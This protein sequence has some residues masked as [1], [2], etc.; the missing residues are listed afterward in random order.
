LGTG[1]FYLLFF[2]K[3]TRWA[4]G[5]CLL[6]IA[7]PLT[8]WFLFPTFQNRIKYVLYDF[9]Y[10]RREHYL[11]AA[12]DGNRIL[13]LKAGYHVLKENFWGVG[14]G[15]VVDKTMHWYDAHVPG[16]LATDKIYPSSE[17]LL[18][19]GFSGWPGFFLF[20]LIMLLPFFERRKT[21]YFFWMALILVMALSFLFDLGLEAQFGVFIYAFIVLWWWKWLNAAAAPNAG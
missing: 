4:L 11:P 6:A 15:D 8:A 17:W 13:S 21:G 1:I 2:L 16:M 12:N 20:T 10:I 5:L 19:G 14:S 18:Y 3:K 9:S 7:M